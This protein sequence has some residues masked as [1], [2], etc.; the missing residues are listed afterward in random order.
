MVGGVVGGVAVATR[1][2]QGKHFRETA[3]AMRNNQAARAA[4]LTLRKMVKVKCMRRM[5]TGKGN[6]CYNPNTLRRKDKASN[7]FRRQMVRTIPCRVAPLSSRV[8]IPF[9]TCLDK[10]V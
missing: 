10:L 9:K 5:K 6:W 8:K 1:K 7:I 2:R 3:T 4:C